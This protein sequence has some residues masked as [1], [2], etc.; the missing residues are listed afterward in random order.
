MAAIFV[1][2][3]STPRGQR[4]TCD[5]RGTR[6]RSPQTMQITLRP[7]QRASAPR[8]LWQEVQRN[9]TTSASTSTG[10]AGIATVESAGA[11]VRRGTGTWRAQEWHSITPEQVAESSSRAVPHPTQKKRIVGIFGKTRQQ[12]VGALEFELD[13]FERGRLLLEVKV[14]QSP[15]YLVVAVRHTPLTVAA[16][17]QPFPPS[18]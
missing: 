3:I 6:V 18:P 7:S 17:Y 2:G 14:K 11:S 12:L 5:H 15:P 16:R 10:N 13:P 9:F 4:G 1:G 8:R